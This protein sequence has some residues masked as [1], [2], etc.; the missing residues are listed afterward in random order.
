[1]KQ[2]QIYS[3]FVTKQGQFK[4]IIVKEQGQMANVPQD[5]P[6]YPARLPGLLSTV[7]WS[8]CAGAMW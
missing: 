6:W 5:G 8:S 3:R 4:S 1:M 2:R 7:P